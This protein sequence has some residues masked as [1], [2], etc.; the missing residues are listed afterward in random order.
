MSF[1]VVS[2]NFRI[3]HNSIASH[4]CLMSVH[5][6]AKILNFFRFYAMRDAKPIY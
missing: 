6:I 2:D 5:V 1:Y 3:N 4:E